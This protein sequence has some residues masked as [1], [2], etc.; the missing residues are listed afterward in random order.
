MLGNT[1]SHVSRQKKESRPAHLALSSLF[2]D[3]P[4]VSPTTTDLK[5]SSLIV[6]AYASLQ[7]EQ[8]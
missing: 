4:R 7:R 3:A 5:P 1:A 8:K 2:R 6:L